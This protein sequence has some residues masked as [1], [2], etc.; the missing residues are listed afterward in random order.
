MLRRYLN[1]YGEY[2]ANTGAQNYHFNTENLRGIG[3]LLI[4]FCNFSDFGCSNCSVWTVSLQT[5]LDGVGLG[6][7]FA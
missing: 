4:P 5:T 7:F 1:I 3:S 6:L 2:Q